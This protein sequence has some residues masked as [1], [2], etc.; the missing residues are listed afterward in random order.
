MSTA[1]ERAARWLSENGGSLEDAGRR[2]G[3]SRQATHSAWVQIFGARPTPLQRVAQELEA[4][5]SAAVAAGKTPSEITKTLQMTRAR[6]DRICKR[7]KLEKTWATHAHEKRAAAV[8]RVVAGACI[9]DVAIEF[10]MGEAAIH[11]MLHA[12]G[13]GSKATGKGRQDGRYAR[14][15]AKVD[16]GMS[17]IEA[18]KQ[19]RCATSGVYARLK[20]RK[21]LCGVDELVKSAGL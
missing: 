9:M 10:E 16:A 13:L 11:R 3:V 2:F 20:R 18:C 7:L 8:A 4:E 21:E 6:F 12:R 1:S 17:V 14:A 15:I 5:V 19:E